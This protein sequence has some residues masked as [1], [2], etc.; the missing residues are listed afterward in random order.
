MQAD[1]AM[2]RVLKDHKDWLANSADYISTRE[3][4]YL[5]RSLS[6]PSPRSMVHASAAIGA[7]AT[8]AG[9]KGVVK[10]SEGDSRSIQFID[11]AISYHLQ[12]IKM[13]FRS[14]QKLGNAPDWRLSLD[15]AGCAMCYCLLYHELE[16]QETLADALSSFV[17]PMNQ[18]EHSYWQER[19]FEPFALQLYRI[20]NGL[21]VKDA[22]TSLA[23]GN[24]YSALL[25][26][27]DDD[28]AFSLNVSAACDYHCKG[29]IDSSRR[30]VEFRKTPF[31]LIA[32]EILALKSVRQAK[33]R[34]F[35]DI[36]HP[37]LHFSLKVPSERKPRLSND[38]TRSIDVFF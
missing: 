32:W 21:D 3:R 15:V 33:G 23:S 25:E 22:L 36:D 1:R 8:C 24:V 29:M 11:E 13:R 30:K 26:S 20:K 7:L 19:I 16:W 2:K 28:A 34:S 14:F 5:A 37:L 38:T 35:P 10:L 18:Q 9:A 12:F 4:D 6:D 17:N 31:D 27:W